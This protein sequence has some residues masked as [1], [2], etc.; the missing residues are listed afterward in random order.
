MKLNEVVPLSPSGF[1]TSL[2]ESIGVGVGVGVGEAAGTPGANATPRNALLVPAV[3]IAENESPADPV[4]VR[5]T[6]LVGVSA[7]VAKKIGWPEPLI[8]IVTPRKPA[9]RFVVKV[10]AKLHVPPLNV[11]FCSPPP[12]AMDLSSAT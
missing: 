6:S 7:V 1:N 3:T 11:H 12:D 4:S 8:D 2:I 9:V 10:L 5:A